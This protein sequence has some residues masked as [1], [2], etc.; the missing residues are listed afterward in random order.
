MST[1]NPITKAIKIVGLCALARELGIPHQSIRKWEKAKRLPR[2]EYTG[3]TAHAEK[4]QIVTKN[5]VTKDELL[6][7]IRKQS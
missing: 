4:I 2:T 3:E 7:L 6:A 5:K 1:V